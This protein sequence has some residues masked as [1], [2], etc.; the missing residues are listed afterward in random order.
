M[1]SPNFAAANPGANPFIS[2]VLDKMSNGKEMRRLNVERQALL[3]SLKATGLAQPATIL[4]FNP[5]P[6][7]LDGGLGFKVPSIIDEAVNDDDRRR[8]KFDGREYKATAL[9]IREPKTFTQIKD[10][11][12]EEEIPNGVYEVKAC[13]QIEIAHCFY[14]AY[15]FGVLGSSTGIGGVL[16]FEGDLRQLERHE[17]GQ[18]LKIRVPK[19][20]NLPNG[21]REY[22][23][24][25]KDFDECLVACLKTQRT[26]CS[27]ATQ[28]AQAF[29]DQEDQRGNITPVHRIWH[30]YEMDMG[31]RQTAAPW[32]TLS[33]E[34]TV[35][36]P[37]CGN[38]KKRVDAFACWSCQRVYEPLE[39][40]MA[41]EIQVTHPSMERIADS[42]W[43][44]VQKEEARRKKLREGV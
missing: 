16:V 22:I 24:E 10:V 21:T 44:K 36:C 25:D 5:I 31:W 43:P 18:R 20:L 40:Y 17:K 27:R 39:A 7:A 35:T 2:N 26:Y 23:T 4:N 41:K 34:N 11:K 12:V 6:L 29:W 42:D 19:Y 15:T 32:I 3:M 8:F 28:E 13:K 38:I 30:Q 9:T 14:M 37:G 1:G 33:T